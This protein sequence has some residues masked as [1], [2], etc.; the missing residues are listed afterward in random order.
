MF[1]LPIDLLDLRHVCRIFCDLASDNQLWKFILRRMPLVIEE[2]EKIDEKINEKPLLFNYI[3]PRIR[4]INTYPKIPKGYIS[5][6]FNLICGICGEN[7]GYNFSRNIDQQFGI[8]GI[9]CCKWCFNDKF[10][11]F[12]YKERKYY[13]T[14]EQNSKLKFIEEENSFRNLFHTLRSDFDNIIPDTKYKNLQLGYFIKGVKKATKRKSINET[15]EN[16][17]KKKRKQ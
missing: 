7:N 11:T 1:F 13:L 15:T 16:I 8:F 10:I 9:Y 3:F 4:Y 17:S 12:S 5:P 2:W 14:N 6:P